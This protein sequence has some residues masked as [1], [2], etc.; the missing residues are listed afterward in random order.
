MKSHHWLIMSGV[1]LSAFLAGLPAQ[2]K[3]ANS[4]PTALGDPANTIGM[5]A[6]RSRDQ[7]QVVAS[8]EPVTRT[9][10][11][12]KAQFDGIGTQ[13][14]ALEQ[15]Y[16]KQLLQ[17]ERAQEDYQNQKD[18][19]D[20]AIRAA[21]AARERVTVNGLSGLKPF[22]MKQCPDGDDHHCQLATCVPYPTRNGVIN[23]CEGR[24]QFFP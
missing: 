17:N 24:D 12:S 3:D 2:A 7:A 23:I 4:L 11:Q 19:Y 14:Q 22:D 13:Y 8:N 1:V 16:Q 15:Q 20:D 21:G 10:D 18:A 9:A 6:A 5:P